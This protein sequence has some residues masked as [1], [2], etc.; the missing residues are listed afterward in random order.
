MNIGTYNEVF[1][2]TN[3]DGISEPLNVTLKVNG[4]RPDWTVNPADYKFNMSVYGQMKINGRFSNDTEDML[5]A[6]E[7][8]V[9]VGVATNEYIK[10]NDMYYALLT[11]YGNTGSHNKLE[12]KMWDA[13]TGK[14]YIVEPET[15]V[16]FKANSIVGSPKVP[17][18][19]SNLD[20]VQLDVAL[21]NGWT[22][23]SF[24]VMDE[25]MNDLS[26]V[27]KNNAWLSGDEVK[28]EDGGVATYGAQTGWVGSLNSLDNE[29]MFMIR[30]SYPQTLSVI[31]S[32]V[33]PANHI[34]DIRSV[35]EQGI[36]VWNYIPYLSQE[37]LPL[38]EA[39]A[40]YEAEMGDVVKS[41]SAFAMW[42]GNLGWIGS[43]TYMQPGRGYM[44]QRTG[45]TTATLRYPSTENRKAKVTT[46]RNAA[47]ETME[48][49]GVENTN[50]ARTMSM[51]A[52]VEGVELAEGDVLRAYINGELRGE[53]P[54]ICQGGNDEPLFFLSVAGEQSGSIDMTVERRG[55]IVASATDAGSFNADAVE[56]TYDNPMVISFDSR[57]DRAVYPS[58]FYNELFI[59]KQV[60]AADKVTVTITD[61]KGA[62]M[63]L[64]TD[65]NEGGQVDIHY[66]DALNLSPGVYMVNICVNGKD[67][68]Y[69]VIKVKR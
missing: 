31:G 62:K 46:K 69:K 11:V 21:N 47:D 68:V 55:E 22:W 56:G 44:L 9:C 45:T 2:L 27:L 12:F 40:G 63:A 30:S 65:C 58:P 24:N 19:F 23:T 37:N 38:T 17:V 10:V 36:A 28:R 66:T 14:I 4:K 59:R 18:V 5:A 49:H 25:D 20:K 39:L 34:L 16:A 50:Y 48:N 35:N 42:N 52:T 51:V 41:Q 60:D 6:F 26:Q 61:A 53:S 43:L 3:S 7:D 13:S 64:L 54:V 8:D 67:N 33:N 57:Y 29:G 1:Y 15:P 32:P